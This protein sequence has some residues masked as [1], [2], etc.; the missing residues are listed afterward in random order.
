M[1]KGT[2][3]A[4]TGDVT[5]GSKPS[6]GAS[7]RVKARVTVS[8]RYRRLV[9]KGTKVRVIVRSTDALGNVAVATKRVTVR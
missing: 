2:R 1:G 9:R 6:T 8:K 4:A 7:N 3:I 5:L